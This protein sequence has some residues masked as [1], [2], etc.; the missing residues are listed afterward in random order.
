MGDDQTG[1]YT[2]PEVTV[3]GDPNAPPDDSSQQ[4]TPY[5]P[6]VSADYGPNWTLDPDKGYVYTGPSEGP[7]LLAAGVEGALTVG[8][9]LHSGVPNP[10]AL[11]QIAVD[12]ETFPPEDPRANA[13]GGYCAPDGT[14]V[15]TDYQGNEYPP[16]SPDEY[17][18]PPQPISTGTE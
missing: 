10:L 11:A 2:I 16:Y 3:Y 8:E 18:N 1:S 15:A 17:G 13:P 6:G 9:V 7:H 14:Y 4:S 12:L 5:A